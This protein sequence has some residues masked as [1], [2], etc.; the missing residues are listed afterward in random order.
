MEPQTILV[1]DDN[2]ASRRLMR[3]ILDRAGYRVLMA[4][5]VEKGL[6]LCRGSI[7]FDLLIVEALLR[8]RQGK[9]VAECFY[10]LRPGVPVLFMSG[11]ALQ[12]LFQKSVL[13]AAWFQ[14]GKVRFL[15]KPFTVSGLVTT[16]SELLREGTLTAG[17][18]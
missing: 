8:T 2:L 7:R 6:A 15:Q 16:V 18:Q 11:H 13:E 9:L 3:L 1:V 10:E 4:K 5:D 12:E 14:R 17:G